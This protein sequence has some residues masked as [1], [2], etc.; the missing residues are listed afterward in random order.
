MVDDIMQDVAIAVLRQTEPLTDMSRVGPWLYRVAMR[1][2]LQHR[3]SHGRRRER[4]NR[5][6][7]ALEVNASE[8]PDPLSAMIAVETKQQLY[9]SLGQLSDQDRELL[10]LRHTQNWTHQQIADQLGIDYDKVVYRVS[11]A[12]KRLRAVW[13]QRQTME[14]RQ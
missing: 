6:A 5:L 7:A 1:Q 8:S 12:K 14:A 3:R 11:R 9:A 4:R 10:L 2:I 13:M